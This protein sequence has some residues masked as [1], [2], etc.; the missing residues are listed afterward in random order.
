MSN[1]IF[2]DH[3]NQIK[4]NQNLHAW[5]AFM[6]S[7]SE[8]SHDNTIFWGIFLPASLILRLIFI[9]ISV[10]KTVRLD[11]EHLWSLL[12][13]RDAQK[14]HKAFPQ[15]YIRPGLWL[16]QSKQWICSWSK[17]LHNIFSSFIWSDHLLTCCI[18]NDFFF[19]PTMTQICL[20]NG[21]YHL[22]FAAFS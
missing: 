7:C 8:S 20:V 2:C 10:C 3:S 6:F 13:I 21:F 4:S 22:I 5:N 15:A 17:P 19:G 1:H 16:D 11:W 14:Q 9:P 18:H 12:L